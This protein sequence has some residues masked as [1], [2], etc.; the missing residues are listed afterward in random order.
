MDVW[1]HTCTL[2][3]HIDVYL[4]VYV[5]AVLMSKFLI[6]AFFPQLVNNSFGWNDILWVERA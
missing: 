5:I 4:W 1:I 3:M 6:F 2:Q